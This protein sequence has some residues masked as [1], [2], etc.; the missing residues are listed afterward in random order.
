MINSETLLNIGNAI[1]GKPVTDKYVTVSGAV[2]NPVTVKVPIGMAIRELIEIAGPT[3]QN[4]SVI[5][6]GPMM[7]SVLANTAE[8]VTKT[9]KGLIVLP[10]GHP[11][12]L[13][14]RISWTHV[15]HRAKSVCCQC[16]K[17]TS[18]CPRYHLGHRME[19]HKVMRS[20]G[21]G[22][23]VTAGDVTRAF[24]CC[25]CGAC[26]TVGCD[27]GLAPNRVNAELKKQLVSAGVKNP[28]NNTQPKPTSEREHAQNTR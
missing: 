3:P 7:G 24:L 21:Q 27:M 20:L 18:V 8:P 23:D 12:L 15:L 10:D 1:N 13:A 26:E 17:C 11:L 2:K 19:P 5:E 4:Y 25:Q 9:T 16:S 28:Y 22:I 6:G 14:K